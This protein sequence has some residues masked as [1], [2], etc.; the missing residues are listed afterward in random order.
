MG[1]R[2]YLS[3]YGTE[4][5]YFKLTGLDNGVYRFDVDLNKVDSVNND[6][7]YAWNG[8]DLI[9]IADTGG[10]ITNQIEVIYC[11]GVVNL[12]CLKL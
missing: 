6:S 2:K 8:K 4:G 12:V 10:I 7:L 9:L 3:S 5:S 11:C 1:D